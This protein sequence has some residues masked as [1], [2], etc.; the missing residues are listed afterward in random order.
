MSPQNKLQRSSTRITDSKAVGT[1]NAR[2]QKLQRS[3]IRIT[4]SK[5]AGTRNAKR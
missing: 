5:A 3:S 2:K 1:R 4:D